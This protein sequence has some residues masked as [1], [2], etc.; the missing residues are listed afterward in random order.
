MGALVLAVPILLGI[1][2]QTPLP[3]YHR[4]LIHI[5]KRVN[6]DTTSMHDYGYINEATMEDK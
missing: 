5:T 6:I 1:W 3:Q 2:H 4:Q